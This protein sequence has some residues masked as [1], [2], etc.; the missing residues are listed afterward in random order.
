[1]VPTPF[2]QEQLAWLILRLPKGR[3]VPQFMSASPARLGLGWD[4]HPT[5]PVAPSWHQAY[6][7]TA[8][9]H[10]A[11]SQLHPGGTRRTHSYTLVAPSIL[12][13]TPW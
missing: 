5:L 13:V 6:S 9:W 12:T 1:M 8:W 7:F 11:Y 2:T 4:P 3:A 10:Q